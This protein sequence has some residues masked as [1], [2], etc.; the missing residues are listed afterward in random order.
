MQTEESNGPYS[1]FPIKAEKYQ[2]TMEEMKKLIPFV[3]EEMKACPNSNIVF[4]LLEHVNFYSM[5]RSFELKSNSSY[6]NSN[7][8]LKKFKDSLIA[9]ISLL[10]S[11]VAVPANSRFKIGTKSIGN[12]L[13]SPLVFDLKGDETRLTAQTDTIIYIYKSENDLELFM[14]LLR[15]VNID[16]AFL[17]VDMN[18]FKHKKWLKAHNYF[19]RGDKFY[20]I[21]LPA[22]LDTPLLGETGRPANLKFTKLPRAVF[23]NSINTIINDKPIEN[24]YSFDIQEDLLKEPE[25]PSLSEENDLNN[26]FILLDN[27]AKKKVVKA[28]NL[29]IKNN[30][31]LEEV[32]F[33]VKSKINIDRN[34][35]IKTKCSP[36]FYGEAK[37]SDINMIENF[38]GVL[39]KQG[40]FHNIQDKVIFKQ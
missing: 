39:N 10:D 24:F 29:H 23:V 18:F 17:A 21:K 5:K 3:K 12:F 6:D 37:E 20:F 36:A 8:A 1:N 9:N 4:S 27:A 14:S 11:F 35:I 28:I 30:I 33:Y 26:N 16:L 40:L 19:G 22:N 31:G 7:L 13:D 34:G 38:I 25:Y 2:Q 15:D 32:H